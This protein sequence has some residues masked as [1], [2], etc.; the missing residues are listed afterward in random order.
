MFLMAGGHLI[1]VQKTILVT[2]TSPHMPPPAGV[3]EYLGYKV[4]DGPD[5]AVNRSVQSVAE[6]AMGSELDLIHK[7]K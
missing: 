6:A 5:L 7:L 3:D 4:P 1:A 2:P